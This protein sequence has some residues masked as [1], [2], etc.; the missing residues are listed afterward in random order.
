M[1]VIATNLMNIKHLFSAFQEDQM[2][3]VPFVFLVCSLTWER[4]TI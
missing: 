2:Q 1:S 3:I 4:E